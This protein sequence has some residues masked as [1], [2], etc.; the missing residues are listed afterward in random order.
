LEDEN[1]YEFAFEGHRYPDIIRTGRA[2]E[3]FGALN[4]VYK[5][6]RY[7]VVPLPT[8]ELKDDPDLEQN[9]DGVY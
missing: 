2:G 8:S 9:G 1:R 7:W 6:P 5:D 3:V 4:P